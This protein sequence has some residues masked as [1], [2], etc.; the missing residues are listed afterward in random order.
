MVVNQKYRVDHNKKYRGGVIARLKSTLFST[1]FIQTSISF[2]SKVL[3]DL[4]WPY[5]Q[6]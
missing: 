4:I 6:N 5:E 2:S 1:Y 3:A